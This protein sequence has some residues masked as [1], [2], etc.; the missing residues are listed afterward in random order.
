M[1]HCDNEAVFDLYLP[2]YKRPP[3]SEKSSAAGRGRIFI[4]C[5]ADLFLKILKLPVRYSLPQVLESVRRSKNENGQR[6]ELLIANFCFAF[7]DSLGGD[8][9]KEE[10]KNFSFG[11]ER[12][13]LTCLLISGLALS[14]S[15]NLTERLPFLVSE[16]SADGYQYYFSRKLKLLKCFLM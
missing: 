14:R 13:P 11:E 9:E 5:G 4:I 7:T 12:R 10:I 8:L 2:T 6:L 16:D 3:L 15:L 1:P